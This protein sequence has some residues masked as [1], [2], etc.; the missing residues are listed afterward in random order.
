VDG[1]SDTT[2]HTYSKRN[3]SFGGLPKMSQE[4]IQRYRHDMPAHGTSKMIGCDHGMF[5]KHADHL[6]AGE[7]FQARI[8]FLD[9]VAE[10]AS[11][12]FYLNGM[13]CINDSFEIHRHY[14]VQ[15]DKPELY[16]YLTDKNREKSLG[17]EKKI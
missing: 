11:E 8:E 17:D 6:K 4:P 5:V 13:D 1:K 2:A 16:K 12:H 14:S 7:A 15:I 3:A 10:Q 9:K